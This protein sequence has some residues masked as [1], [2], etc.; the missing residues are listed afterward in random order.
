[1]QVQVQV[2]VLRTG[3]YAAWDEMMLAG[4]G[5]RQVEKT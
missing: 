5:I 3:A 1:V 4:T 2:Q